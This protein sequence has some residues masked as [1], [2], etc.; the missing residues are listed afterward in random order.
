MVVSNKQ[1]LRIMEISQRLSNTQKLIFK[2]HF[3]I[4]L[5][6]IIILVES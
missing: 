1:N 3:L 2:I 4:Y 5:M 6:K